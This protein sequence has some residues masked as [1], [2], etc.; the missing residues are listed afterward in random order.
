MLQHSLFPSL[1]FLNQRSI[2]SG[3]DGFRPT[4]ETLSIPQRLE[5]LNR[6][7]PPSGR[8]GVRPAEISYPA[9]YFAYGGRDNEVQPME[10]TLKA[11]EGYKGTVAYECRAEQG[12]QFDQDPEE[13]CLDFRTWL[14]EHLL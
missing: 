6:P 13:E 10:K 8:R 14:G 1:L 7:I 2:G 11:L 12:H 9:I 4:P 3:L 5:L